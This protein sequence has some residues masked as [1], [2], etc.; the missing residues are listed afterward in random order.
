MVIHGEG[1]IALKEVLVQYISGR[2]EYNFIKG[3]ETISADVHSKFQYPLNA[4]KIMNMD[5]II[6]LNKPT[7]ALT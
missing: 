6:E 4:D 1:E 3:V 5:E 2:G 7:N